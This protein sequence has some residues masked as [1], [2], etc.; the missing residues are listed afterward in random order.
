[1]RRTRSK[2][3]PAAAKQRTTPARKKA[4]AGDPYARKAKLSEPAMC[5]TCGLEYRKG[6]WVRPRGA[7]QAKPVVCPACQR[8]ADR[9]PAGV[10]R[11]SG[12]YLREHRDEIE[13]LIRHVEEREQRNHPLKRVMAIRAVR[14]GLEV[15]T[16]DAKLAQGIGAALRRA[17]HGE[18]ET[19]QTNV[20]A[21]TRVRWSR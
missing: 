8:T 7:S 17:H 13:R 15:T 4:G 10:V 14:G 21:V 3:H 20:E 12:A 18:L 9:Y 19:D 16:T 6:R 5:R 11:L 2:T 1:M